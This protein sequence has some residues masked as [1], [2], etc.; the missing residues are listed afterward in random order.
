VLLAKEERALQGAADRLN[1]TGRCCGMEMNLE[2]NKVMTVSRQPSVVQIMTDLKQLESVEYFNSFG[3]TLTNDARC[4]CEMKS[5]VSRAKIAINKK[6]V[7]FTR[8]LDVNLRNIPVNCH[9]WS[10]TVYGVETWTFLKLDQ[11]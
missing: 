1:E 3:C 11:K 4:T 2:K 5:G 6:N 7:L 10:T 9:I 8:K